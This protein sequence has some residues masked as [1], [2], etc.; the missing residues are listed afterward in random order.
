MRDPLIRGLRSPTIRARLLKNLMLDFRIAIQ[1]AKSLE[2]AQLRS[3]SYLSSCGHL[4]MSTAAV[5]DINSSAKQKIHPDNEIQ[6]AAAAK[7]R[8]FCLRK[9]NG[10]NLCRRHPNDNRQ[11]CPA[12]DAVCLNGR[13]WDITK[14]SNLDAVHLP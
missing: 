14:F 13:K 12:K 10:F 9:L 2:H 4:S 1:L 5:V 6:T 3:D 8:S 11:L 7:P